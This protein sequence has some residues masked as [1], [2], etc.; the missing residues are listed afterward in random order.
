M[1]KTISILI[2]LS[3]VYQCLGCLGVFAWYG[4][5]KQRIAEELC[6]N[7]GRPELHC[8]GQ[9]ILME[10][11]KALEDKETQR[12]GD[13]HANPKSETVAF[14][15]PESFVLHAPTVSRTTTPFPREASYQYL[16]S[17]DN[18]RPPCPSS[19]FA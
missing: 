14:L 19:P 16:Y 10:K 13:S 1:T 3:L 8:N 15:L 11:L 18:F 12:T 9:C 2:L 6:E 4:A 7:R 5:N 17:A